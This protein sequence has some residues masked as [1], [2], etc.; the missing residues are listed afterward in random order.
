MEN[1][2]KL[3]ELKLI[4]LCAISTLLFLLFLK[5]KDLKKESAK[6]ALCIFINFII[7]LCAMF[8]HARRHLCQRTPAA[9]A[10]QGFCRTA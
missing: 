5:K 4:L 9:S 2:L 3:T 1:L 6:S 8:Y 10:W 7:S